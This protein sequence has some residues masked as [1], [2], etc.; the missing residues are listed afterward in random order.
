MKKYLALQAVTFKA[1]RFALTAEQFAR[2]RYVVV[3]VGG[4]VY[5]PKAEISFKA[6]EIVETDLDVPKALQV[7]LEPVLDVPAEVEFAA[8]EPAEVQAPRQKRGR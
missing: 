1:G 8:Q 7:R 5:E 3:P 6:G 4:N 2:R